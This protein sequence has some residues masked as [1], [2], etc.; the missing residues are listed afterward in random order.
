MCSKIFCL[1]IHC[2]CEPVR[3]H[4][5]FISI[6]TVST[7]LRSLTISNSWHIFMCIMYEFWFEFKHYIA[8]HLMNNNNNNSQKELRQTEKLTRLQDFFLCCVTVVVVVHTSFH[9]ETACIHNFNF[10]RSFVQFS[11]PYIGTR[12]KVYARNVANIQSAYHFT[13]ESNCFYL[14]KNNN[15]NQNNI[16]HNSH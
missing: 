16:H 7:L 14:L 1:C 11:S 13:I 8:G 5:F 10:L 3:A 6:R 15:N 12:F 4:G 9:H 2:C